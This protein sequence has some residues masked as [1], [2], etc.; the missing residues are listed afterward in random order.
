MAK[1]TKI[2][3]AFNKGEWSALLDALIGVQGYSRACQTMENFLALIQGGA[4]KRPGTIFA[5]EV[6]DSTKKTRMVDFER[7]AINAYAMEVGNQYIRFFKN[8]GRVVVGDVSDISDWVTATE[9][10]VNN[11]REDVDNAGDIYICNIAHTSGT[12][13]T[14]VAAGKWTQLSSDTNNQFIYEIQTPYL[15]AD[16]FQLKFET[17]ND[18]MWITHPDYESRKLSRFSDTNFVLTTVEHEGGPFLPQNTT[19]VTITPDNN[20]DVGDTV[21]LTASAA[22]FVDGITA[23]HEPSGPLPTDKSNTGA[24]FQ[25]SH[26]RPAVSEEKEFTAAA[27]NTANITVFKGQSIDYITQGL[28]TGTLT[29]ERSYD[30]VTPSFE[31][32][33]PTVSQNNANDKLLHT[34]KNDTALYRISSSNFGGSFT[35]TATGRFVV[36]SSLID[37]V[38]QITSVASTTSAAGT[39]LKQLIST[40]ATD[41][42]SEGAWSNK[43][44]WPVAV[45]ISPDERLTFAANDAE[46]LTVWTSKTSVFDDF[47]DGPNADDALVFTL[48]GIGQQNQILWVVSKNV[49]LLGTEGGEHTLGAI[50]GKGPMTPSTTQAKVQS[51]L[52]SKNIQP[53]IVNSAVLFIQRGG[54]RIR[55]MLFSFQDDNYNSD[56]LNDFAP[57][58]TESGIT[59]LEYQRAPDPVVWAPR[60]DGQMAV[61]S[62]ERKQEIFSWARFI[63]Y[64]S[65][66][67]VESDFESVAVISTNTE[68]DK[69]YV[70]VKRII[71]GNVV[72]YVEFFST[73]GF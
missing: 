56:N 26:I 64:T 17:S 49:L 29:F 41:E 22:V 62:Y 23:G 39:V 34:E 25:L 24:L 35:G 60:S 42:W 52:G 40:D 63:T 1:I 73:R 54:R 44:G 19:S 12:F 10:I 4:E 8:N 36:R 37:G 55:E 53:L 58:V 14:D 66:A 7:S 72:R 6:K 30:L 38:V 20:L 33:F 31:T 61:M 65:N 68:E 59:E 2:I 69:V 67:T 51:T 18:V 15:T 48:V 13:A 16:L 71:N 3:Q 5:G 45:T 47:T 46:P 57:H 27:Q 43:N 70:I 11:A 9:Y 32:V 28:W 50:D 21:T